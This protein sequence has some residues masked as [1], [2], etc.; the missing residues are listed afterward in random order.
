MKLYIIIITYVSQ[1]PDEIKRREVSWTLTKK[2]DYH[3]GVQERS[4]GGR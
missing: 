3:L 1:S 4:R 2:L